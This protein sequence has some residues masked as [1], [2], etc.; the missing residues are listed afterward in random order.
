MHKLDRAGEDIEN[1]NGDM[2]DLRNEIKPINEN[3]TKI[4]AECP[5]FDSK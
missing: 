5:I 3:I 4:K 1:I 2:K